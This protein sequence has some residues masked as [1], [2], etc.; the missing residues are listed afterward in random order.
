MYSRTN[1]NAYA[2]SP[3]Y[4]PSD[5][6][7]LLGPPPPDLRQRL[8]TVIHQ[9]QALGMQYQGLSLAVRRE[10]KLPKAH[11]RFFCAAVLQQPLVSHGNHKV[12]EPIGYNEIYEICP[13]WI[14]WFSHLND[15]VMR[16]Q[17]LELSYTFTETHLNEAKEI[18][19]L[20]EDQIDRLERA[21]FE[22]VE[23]V[24]SS[25]DNRSDEEIV[26]DWN[27]VCSDISGD[28][29]IKEALRH[30]QNGTRNQPLFGDYERKYF[31]Y[32]PINQAQ[33]D[34]HFPEATNSEL[35]E[36][37]RRAQEE[38]QRQQQQSSFGDRSNFYG[39]NQ[40]HQSGAN[41]QFRG[42]GGGRGYY[43]G[44][45]YHENGPSGGEES[46]WQSWSRGGSNTRS[47]GYGRG[48]G[49]YSDSQYH[50]HGSFG[51]DHSSW[52]GQSKADGNAQFRGRGRGRGHYNARQHHQH[53]FFGGD[54][55]FPTQQ[56]QP[57][58][59]FIQPDTAT[60]KLALEKYNNAWSQLAP[61]SSI[62]D[63]PMPSLDL[64]L[65]PLSNLRSLDTT[66][67]RKT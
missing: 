44:G 2:Q 34:N 12:T 60:Y 23:V 25:S 63:A 49:H 55:R 61:E 33:W 13:L 10:M 3:H 5:Y 64:K 32:T 22:I 9:Y 28:L 20:A 18:L 45:Q 54:G 43:S 50:E 7:H 35:L 11:L 57:P 51:R 39:Q 53:G 41:W 14:D 56:P 42:R 8:N 29:S 59:Q 27:S 6:K 24:N 52:Q 37:K 66:K 67:L 46:R 4:N 15:F 58:A 19:V 48:R 21:V 1:F 38:Q 31:V 26:N 30:Y 36:K 65:S 16:L 40:G 17:S 62:N 47:Y